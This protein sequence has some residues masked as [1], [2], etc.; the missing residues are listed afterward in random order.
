ML[1]FKRFH[2]ELE[3]YSGF[4]WG[5]WHGGMAGDRGVLNPKLD[6]DGL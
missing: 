2:Y 5:G 1:G 3:N 6:S 4:G